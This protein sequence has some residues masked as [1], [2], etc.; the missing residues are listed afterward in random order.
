[1][2]ST[3]AWVSGGELPSQRL[4][5]YT[6]GLAAAVGFLGAVSTSLIAYMKCPIHSSL[7]AYHFHRSL[8]H[9]RRIVE[10]GVSYQNFLSRVSFHIIYQQYWHFSPKYGYIWFPSCLIAAAFIYFFLP[11]VK[12]RTLEEIDEMVS[13]Y[14]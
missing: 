5:S 9:Q 11:E 2:V 4:R 14:K 13:S 1:M 8:F 6:F 7:V 12:G 10:L 3:Y